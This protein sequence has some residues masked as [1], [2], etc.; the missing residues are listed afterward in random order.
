[1]R[2]TLCLL[3]LII[4]NLIFSQNE[5]IK[6][7][8]I[9]FK[10]EQR[11]NCVFDEKGL[12][13]HKLYLEANFPNLKHEYSD[14]ETSEKIGFIAIKEFSENDLKKLYSILYHNTHIIEGSYNP[15]ENYTKF[16]VTRDIDYLNNSFERLFKKKFK[17]FKYSVKI[18]YNSKKIKF[19]YPSLSDQQLFE[20]NLKEIKYAEN[21]SLNGKYTYKLQNRIYTDS[22][23]LNEK[24]SS[25]IT[26]YI[27][28]SNAEFG[29]QKI[30]NVEYTTDLKS[31]SN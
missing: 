28:F 26:P 10:Y 12:Y 5:K 19:K 11:P 14:N 3:A 27:L 22:V 23:V 24:Y 1:M 7:A 30:I 6:S 21:D 2:K 29:V 20:E 18:D 13:A 16:V 31:Y 4:G 9:T 25:K 15:S 8:L 17:K